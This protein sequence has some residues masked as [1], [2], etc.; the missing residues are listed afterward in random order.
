MLVFWIPVFLAAYPGYFSYDA[1]AQEGQYRLGYIISWHPVMHTILIGFFVHTIGNLFG[2]ANVGIALYII[3]QMILCS[4]CFTYCIY[5][6]D[7]YKV[8]RII[9]RI[10]ILYYTIFPVIVMFV[11]CSTRDTIFTIMVLFS[12][13]FMTEALIDKEKFVNSK[14]LQF[15]FIL[16]TF[17][18]LIFRNNGIYAY[19]PFFIIFIIAFRKKEILIPTSIILTLYVGMVG[20]VYSLLGVYTRFTSK[21]EAFSVPLQ[22]I[23][24]VY[25][26]NYESLTE[27]EKEKILLYTSDE[28]LKKYNPKLSDPIKDEVDLKNIGY[29]EFLKLWLEIGI[30]NPR[31]IYR[32]IF[33]KYFRILVS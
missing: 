32:F 28:Q 3:L 8:S 13:M 25:N 30:K 2:S 33:S 23:A 12:I 29:V 4:A 31:N 5:F 26:Y 9:Q 20:G 10:G 27:D 18:A 1:A 17:L 15:R 21:S 11:L 22:Q 19:V 7:K 16:V 14:F 6:L 24:R